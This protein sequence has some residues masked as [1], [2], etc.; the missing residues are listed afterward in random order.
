MTERD[1]PEF[2]TIRLSLPTPE[3]GWE[4]FFSPSPKMT[5]NE[6]KRLRKARRDQE[7]E[8]AATG[9]WPEDMARALCLIPT[10]VPPD[11]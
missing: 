11:A 7:R 6:R 2:P 1:K 4:Q 3:P 10:R 5:R 8:I 9:A